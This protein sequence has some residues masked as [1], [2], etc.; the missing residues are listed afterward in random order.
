MGKPLP[1]IFYRRRTLAV[2]RELLG[3]TLCRRWHGRIIRGRITETE[4]YC[5]S[6]DLASHASRGKTARTAVMFG[7][8]GHI[9]VYLVYGMYWCLNIVTER[10]GYPA[11]VLIRA[12]MV[13]GVPNQKTNGPGK[14]CRYFQI[15]RTLNAKPLNR[16]TGLWIEPD[17]KKNSPLPMRR[18]PRI[19]VDYAG[20][21]RD[22]LWRFVLT[23]PTK[24]YSK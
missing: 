23:N 12:A 10:D 5:G 18:T 9:Y 13:T 3:C 4:A 24:D 15:N 16:K 17:A 2:A 19:G 8:P 6:H 7:P 22:K 11:A 20:A 14:L 1:G 21:Y